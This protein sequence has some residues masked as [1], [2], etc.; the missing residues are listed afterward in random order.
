MLD[1]SVDDLLMQ[2]LAIQTY[3]MFTLLIEG[4]HFLALKY[5][6]QSHYGLSF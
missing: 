3:P 4:Y 2:C 5:L 6:S 1:K